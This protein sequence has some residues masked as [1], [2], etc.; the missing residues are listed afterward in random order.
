MNICDITF[1]SLFKST[2]G[3]THNYYNDNMYSSVFLNGIAVKSHN[4]TKSSDFALRY[5]FI[6]RRFIMF[7]VKTSITCSAVVCQWF[8]EWES[9]IAVSNLIIV[10]NQTLVF[11]PQHFGLDFLEHILMLNSELN[12]MSFSCLHVTLSKPSCFN[13]F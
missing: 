13:Y 6:E 2:F 12:G 4:F 8:S 11:I 1:E 5:D 3:K 7:V 10:C 9:L